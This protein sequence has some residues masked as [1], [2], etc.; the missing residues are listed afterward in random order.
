MRDGQ[1]R[2]AGGLGFRWRLFSTIWCSP[3]GGWTWLYF[4]LFALYGVMLSLFVSM[5]AW[6]EQAFTLI[7]FTSVILCCWHLVSMSKLHVLDPLPIR[8]EYI[9]KAGQSERHRSEGL[10]ASRAEM[11]RGISGMKSQH[12]HAIFGERY[13]QRWIRSYPEIARRYYPEHVS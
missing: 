6:H 11:Q 12:R 9:A 8:A 4:P 3:F 7:L 2:P 1:P 10:M 5:K 13:W